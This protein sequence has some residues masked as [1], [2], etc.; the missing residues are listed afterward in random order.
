MTYMGTSQHKNPG[1][2]KIYNLGRPFL[3]D[4]YYVL[5]LFEPCPGAE[6]NIFKEIHQF[7]PFYPKI[8]SPWG[9]GYEIYNILPPYQ[10]NATYKICLRLAK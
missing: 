8:T 2:H 6:M 3:G 7:Y 5:N 10:T 4:H 1:C 9:G